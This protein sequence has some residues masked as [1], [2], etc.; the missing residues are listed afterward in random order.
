MGF[1]SILVYKTQNVT[2]LLILIS[3]FGFVMQ[4]HMQSCHE[5]IE[6]ELKPMFERMSGSNRHKYIQFVME[7]A[8]VI[9]P[10]AVSLFGGPMVY[11]FDGEFKYLF[12]LSGTIQLVFDLLVLLMFVG[13]FPYKLPAVAK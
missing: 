8:N 10:V 13:L 7:L 6:Q 9:A 12:L 11:A 3:L 2:W 5:L 4:V 1:L